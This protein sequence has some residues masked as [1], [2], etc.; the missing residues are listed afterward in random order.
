[1]TG[2]EDAME[3]KPVVLGLVG[4]AIMSVFVILAA[5]VFGVL[6][7][8]LPWQY[9]NWS[10]LGPLHVV[11]LASFLASALAVY[12]LPPGRRQGPIMGNSVVAGLYGGV[13]MAVSV[14]LAAS[15]VEGVIAPPLKY[16]NPYLLGA[17]GVFL[18]ANFFAG[19][20]AAAWLPTPR[21]VALGARVG[22]LAG[23]AAGATNAALTV[24]LLQFGLKQSL[25]PP[26][27]PFGGL[28]GGSI[29]FFCAGVVA[30]VPLAATLGA[31][32]GALFAALK[33]R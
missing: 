21:T 18:L 27:G 3:V 6:G 11:V 9:S 7:F 16:W 1:L 2:E 33:R 23:L 26:T 14:N 32:G 31:L 30:W 19:V 24:F 25:P 15:I 29:D 20:S 4:G 5:S 22:V 8:V 17:L 28:N 10:T 13:V 12:W